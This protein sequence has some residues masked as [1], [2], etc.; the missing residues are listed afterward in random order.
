MALTDHGACAVTRARTFCTRW[1]LS[2]L[3]WSC[4]R[5]VTFVFERL[6]NIRLLLLAY[7][8]YVKAFVNTYRTS[9]PTASIVGWKTRRGSKLQFSDRLRQTS[10]R[11]DRSCVRKIL[12]LPL[13]FFQNSGFQPQILHFWTTTF[14]QKPNFLTVSRHSKIGKIEHRKSEKHSNSL[15]RWHKAPT[16]SL[17]KNC[18]NVANAQ[19]THRYRRRRC[20]F[21]HASYTP[22]PQK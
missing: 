17:L 18:K 7:Y 6:V 16:L 8:Y 3:V 22:C 21:S 20:R 9:Y 12:T 15:I 4:R 2:R 1:S 13:N 19:S 5:L 14:R 11:G 10:S